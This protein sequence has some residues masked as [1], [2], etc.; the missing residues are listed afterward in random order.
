MATSDVASS[1]L[2]LVLKPTLSASELDDVCALV[3]EANWNQLAADWGVFIDRGRVYAMQ[4]PD[5]RT[6]ATTATLPY[7]RFAWISMVLV[8]GAYRRRGLATLLMRRAMQ[9][10]AESD[11]VPILD[12]TPEG[13]AVYRTL[14]FED[15]WGF[16]RLLRRERHS[17]EAPLVSATIGIRPIADQDWPALCAYDGAAFGAE[18][19]GV[20]R[21]LRGRLPPAELIAERGGH[22]AG[23]LLGRD[24][25][26]APHVGPLIADDDTVAQALLACA[27]ARLDTAVF[28]DLANAKARLRSWLEACGFAA[29]RPFTRMIY[30]SPRRY[31]DAQRTY[32]VVGP[33]FG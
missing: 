29:V 26:L 8:A 22:I 7:D 30:G 33:E 23:F 21:G 20:L 25:G 14:G 4:S 32:A 11:L 27:L 16:N 18:R 12:A 1:E 3:R 10:L 28:I 17:V 15:S 19:G 31:D 13:R 6:V 5:G 2:Q 9:D 24:G